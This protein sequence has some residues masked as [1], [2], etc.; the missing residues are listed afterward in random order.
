MEKNAGKTFNCFLNVFKW[1]NRWNNRLLSLEGVNDFLF[2]VSDH[3]SM[4]EGGGKNICNSIEGQF[5]H[6]KTEI[7]YVIAA[8]LS[9]EKRNPKFIFKNSVVGFQIYMCVCVCLCV[10][11]CDVNAK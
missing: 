4:I 5:L 8:T 2:V 7:C 3:K 6:K 10:S 1:K 11:V 9:D